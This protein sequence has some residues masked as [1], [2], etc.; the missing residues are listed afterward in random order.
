MMADEMRVIDALKK[1]GRWIWVDW[2]QRIQKRRCQGWD[3][4]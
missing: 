1:A 3:F 2:H 4:L